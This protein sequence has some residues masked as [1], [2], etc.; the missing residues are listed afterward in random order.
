MK[1]KKELQLTSQ[2]IQNFT[3]KKIDGFIISIILVL[4]LCLRLYQ[5][6]NVPLTDWNSWRQSDTAAVARN[7]VKNEFNLLYPKSYDLSKYQSGMYNPEGYRLI[8]FPIYNTSFAAIY[9]YFPLF[10][11]ETYGRIISVV[12]S[13]LLIYLIYYL[14]LKEEGR[15][16]AVF[17]ALIFSCMPFFIFYSRAVLP[18]MMALSIIFLSIFFMYLA[19]DKTKKIPFYICVFLSALTAAIAILIK[20]TT[21]I[22]LIPIV[23]LLFK[24]YGLDLLKKIPFYI[25]FLLTL[26]PFILWR[27]WFM[28][29]PEGIPSSEWLFTTITNPDE[30]PVHFRPI[31]FRSVFYDRILNLILGGFLIFPLLLGLLK[32]PQRSFFLYF[33]GLSSLLYLFIFQRENIVHDY[34]QI[35]ILPSL[36]IFC[37]IGINFIFNKQKLFSSILLNIVTVVFILISSFYFSY[38]K[39]KDYYAYNYDLVNIAKIINT[40]TS[41]EDHIITDTN[42]DTTLLYLSDRK[43]YPAITDELSILHE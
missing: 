8:E 17:A 25:F 26:M 13:L 27:Y 2:G 10:N 32:K 12:F 15:I 42:G 1:Q 3:F 24:R 36:A 34:Y 5:L 39:V 21:I 35:M 29:F 43:G 7:F 19:K 31:F 9:K 33:I 14:T 40:L 38:F 30:I 22:F 18:D 16:A 23:Y 6:T 20:V 41:Q 11:L 28:K 4:A 37:G